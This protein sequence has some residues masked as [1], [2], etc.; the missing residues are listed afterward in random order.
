MQCN[1]MIFRKSYSHCKHCIRGTC[2]VTA[3]KKKR[4]Y[5][6]FSSS[7]TPYSFFPAQ[8]AFWFYI[9]NPK[10]GS[11]VGQSTLKKP[12]TPWNSKGFR[13]CR[14]YSHS[15]KEMWLSI[16]LVVWFAVLPLH[17]YVLFVFF[18]FTGLFVVNLS[19]DETPKNILKQVFI[20]TFR[21]N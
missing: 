6:P 21:S 10:S 5:A 15:I 18:S 20:N 14:D 8:A 3:W 13:I 1:F 12:E 19:S 9:P 7:I 16:Y 11:K 2:A 17:I 4:G